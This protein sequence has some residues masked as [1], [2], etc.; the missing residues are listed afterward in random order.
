[1]WGWHPHKKVVAPQRFSRF[2]GMWGRKP[3]FTIRKIK[4]INSHTFLFFY[5]Y[6]VFSAPTSPHPHIFR[7]RDFCYR[8]NRGIHEYSQFM[9]TNQFLKCGDIVGAIPTFIRFRPHNHQNNRFQLAISAKYSLCFYRHR[10]FL[11]SCILCCS[12]S[13]SACLT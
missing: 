11:T 6:V 4:Y 8:N 10:F 5:I 12:L 9:Q 2:V 13:Q 1:M 7:K 3:P